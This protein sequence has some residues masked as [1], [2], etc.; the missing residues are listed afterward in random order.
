LQ[1][2]A[3]DANRAAAGL[4]ANFFMAN[5]ALRTASSMLETTA[6]NTR[7]NAL[8]IEL[9]RR[10]SGG[11]L[12]QGSYQHQFARQGW[13]QRSL[14]E[15]WRYIDSTGGPIHSFKLNWVFELPFGQGKR[16]GSGAGRYMDWLIGGWE[17]DGIARV[18]SGS[19]FNF[20]GYRLVGMTAKDLQSMFKI[21]KVADADGRIRVYMLPEDVIAQ[22]RIALSQQSATSATGYSGDLPTGRYIAPAS[23][24]DCV[25]YWSGMCPGTSEVLKINGPMYWKVD[26]SFVKRIA[27]HKNMRLE[28]RMDLYNVFDTVNF[29][30]VGVGGSALTSWEVTSGQR[31]DSASQDPG[32]RITQFS[33]RFS[34]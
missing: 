9:R 22:S 13:A 31:D 8:Q 6:G 34:W 21:R 11:L 16:F 2:A 27:V 24:P 1:N 5:P 18:Q 23:S 26:F 20:G 10:I 17:W 15:D 30:A 32:G 14:R 7:Y 25:Q 12:V 29:I 28:A 4:P 33:L 3:L 19:I